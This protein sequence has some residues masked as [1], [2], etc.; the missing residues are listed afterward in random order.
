[1]EYTKYMNLSAKALAGEISF[2]E[3]RILK[4]WLKASPE[5]QDIFNKF[6]HVW[7]H[8]EPLMPTVLPGIEEEWSAIKVS[9]GLKTVKTGKKSP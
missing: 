4:K 9:L 6:S 8:A 1:M 2:K 5:N 7:Q 3:K